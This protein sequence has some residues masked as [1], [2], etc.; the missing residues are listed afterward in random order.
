M[1]PRTEQTLVGFFVLIAA[2]ILLVAV[3]AINGAF[4]G[5]GKSYHAH[6]NFAGGLEPGATVRY[7]GGPK[8]GRVESLRID[9]QDATRIDLTFSVQPD[10]QVKTDSRVKIMS[11]SPLGDNHLELYAGSPQAA[12]APSGSLLPSDPYVDFNA[13]TERINDL[14]PAAQQLV[15]T[16][17]ARAT[18]LKVTLDRVNDLLNTKNRA[19]LSATLAD[20][21]AL[22]ADSRPQ[23]HTALQHVNDL[24]EKLGPLIDDFRATSDRANLVLAHLD[25]TVGETQPEIR[26][27]VT[28][29]RGTLKS[30]TQ[31]T[32]QLNQTLD[33]N[34]ENIDQLLDNLLHVTEN[35]KQFTETIKE[36][37]YS[38]IRTTNPR[39]HKTGEQ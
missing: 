29:L 39:E 11:L 26:M 28:E 17:D 23:L 36:R 8:V 5:A 19:N 35:L 1:R 22:I 32:G 6:F 10:V 31:L 4:G 12:V 25:A 38:L 14:A 18:E 7:S 2:G 34:S 13:L 27:A 16:L 30:L 15:Q 24:S 3:F 21:H 9:P 37:P 20:T 33:V